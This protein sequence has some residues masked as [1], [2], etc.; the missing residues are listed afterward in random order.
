MHKYNNDNIIAARD[1]LHI[2]LQDGVQIILMILYAVSN[3]V[4]IYV[5]MYSQFVT[6][7]MG[8]QHG[9]RLFQH[10]VLEWI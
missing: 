4:M 6:T 7:T 1:C 2:I 9:S 3:V 5:S 8:I 10:V